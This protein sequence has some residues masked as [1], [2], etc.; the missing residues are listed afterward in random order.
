M[1]THQNRPSCLLNA[2]PLPCL[3]CES[4]VA[5]TALG[6]KPE[7]L[8]A[9]CLKCHPPKIQR[10]VGQLWMLVA[11]RA[12]RCLDR[13]ESWDSEPFA[14]LPVDH[15]LRPLVDV[16]AIIEGRDP[17][18]LG[19][20]GTGDGVAGDGVAGGIGGD[21]DSWEIP[22]G[23]VDSRRAARRGTGHEP[24]RDESLD[25]WFGRCRRVPK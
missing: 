5:W 21:W 10:L 14:W 13:G 24:E 3:V 7:A 11:V 1:P 6:A 9:M 15:R 18:G 23:V 20:D 16:E 4:I 17:T 12:G 2:S 25:E 19:D 8:N 22:T